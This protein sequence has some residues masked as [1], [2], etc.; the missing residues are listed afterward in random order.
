MADDENSIKVIFEADTSAVDTALKKTQSVAQKSARQISQQ[1]KGSIKASGELIK[2]AN[3]AVGID[4]KLM[5]SGIK[6]AVLENKQFTTQKNQ[7]KLQVGQHT[8]V[9]KLLTVQNKEQ[10]KSL[11]LNSKLLKIDTNRYKTMKQLGSAWKSNQ[12]AY[13]Q[14]Q[15][16]RSTDAAAMQAH[17]GT[18]PPGVRPPQDNEETGEERQKSEPIDWS[19]LI[20]PIAAAVRQVA[21]FVAQPMM[22]G[23]QKYVQFGRSLGRTVGQG[24]D[25]SID[26]NRA[27]QL[28]FSE[29]DTIDQAYGAA[30]QTG[31]LGAVRTAQE[32]SRF[33][34]GSVDEASG[35]M[36]ALTRGGARFDSSG[37]G[38]GRTQLFRMLRDATASGLDRS[39]VGEHLDAVAGAIE[40]TGQSMAGDVSSSNISGL[41]ALIGSTGRSGF[42]GAR[43]MNVLSQI[44]QGFKSGGRDEFSDARQLAAYGFG[45]PGQDTDYYTARRRRDQGIFGG[46]GMEGAQNLSSMLTHFLETNVG[47]RQAAIIDAQESGLFGGLGI[48]QLEGLFDTFQRTGGDMNSMV[49]AIDDL[50][51]TQGSVEEQIRDNL[52]TGQAEVAD[53]IA[54]LDNRLIE[55]GRQVFPAITDI[56]NAVMDVQDTLLP[57]AITI[58]RQIATAVEALVNFFT[59]HQDPVSDTVRIT[60]PEERRNQALP[61]AENEAARFRKL[62][63]ETEA[64]EQAQ[65][66]IVRA[67]PSMFGGAITPRAGEDARRQ[68]EALAQQ[69]QALQERY[70]EH[71]APWVARE[72]AA[73]AQQQASVA[74]AQTPA[75]TVNVAPAQANVTVNVP[76]SEPA[77]ARIPV[78]GGNTGV[79][80]GSSW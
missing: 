63:Q 79:R 38:Q 47:N 10:Q 77:N 8:R 74:T 15:A 52:Q 73:R 61:L 35:Y 30:R 25:A 18:R 66:D 54:K 51:E 11:Q 46:Q 16:K 41:L 49:A 71:I 50:R 69:G 32:T 5:K 36:G 76:A 43:G 39:R 1:D 6:A 4:T 27:Q 28:A 9:G 23:Y 53:R 31:H 64:A 57:T 55:L 78:S 68:A 42:Q 19:K 24:S 56:Q 72:R 20:K 22:E 26:Y 80:G 17:I 58:L 12:S 44:D 75:P 2:N 60:T 45:V 7:F 48:E 59:P 37:G 3:K 70:D 67:N 40:S 34:G 62:I 14:M 29:Q 21:Q 13:A 33:Y 65:W